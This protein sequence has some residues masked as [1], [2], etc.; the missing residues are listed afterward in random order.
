MF[1]GE[2]RENEVG[3]GLREKPLP[4][5]RTRIASPNTPGAYGDLLLLDVIASA[6]GIGVGSDKTGQPLL[7]IIL[8]V[9]PG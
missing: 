1:L 2:C 9:V 6:A 4:R 3:V 5:L 8:H 7:L